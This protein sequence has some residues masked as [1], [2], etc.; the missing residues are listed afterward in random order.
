MSDT[1]LY[2]TTLDVLNCGSCGIPFAMPHNIHQSRKSDGDWF[3]CPNGDK[4]HYS[5]PEN[6]KL[7]RD[8]DYYRNRARHLDDQLDAAERS[9]SGRGRVSSRLAKRIAEVYDELSMT[10][11]PDRACAAHARRLGYSPP[12]A[13]TDETIEGIADGLDNKGIAKA[14]FVSVDTVKTYR[15]RLYKRLGARTA[16]QVVHLG[17]V[18]GLLKEKA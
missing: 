1:L 12:L 3:W 4:I 18:H 9:R 14:L 6:Q 7:K 5:T 8:L 11:G 17:H 16:G 2:S 10:R 15:T 13:W